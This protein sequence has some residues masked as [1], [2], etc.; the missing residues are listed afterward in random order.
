MKHTPILA[1][2]LIA[3]PALAQ[4]SAQTSLTIY[5]QDFA[6]VRSHVPLDLKEG[7]TEVTTTNVT[8][9]LEPDSVVLRDPAS[10][11]SFTIAEQNY[12][13]GV[14]N[15]DSL[16]EKFE[17][18][19]IDFQPG[20]GPNGAP[21]PTVQGTIIRAGRNG[22]QPLINSG[23]HLQ[24]L[25]PGTPL[26]PASTDGL[27]LKPTLRWQIYSPHAARLDAELA[28]ITHGMSWQSTYN[29]IAPETRDVGPTERGEV[30]GAVTIHNNTGTEFADA[31]IKLM[32][33]DVAKLQQLPVNGRAMYEMRAMA[34]SAPAPQVTQQAFDDFHLYDLNRSV[35]L[36]D[37]ET[38]Q[39]EFL[40]ATD[41]TM[42][43]VYEY[44]GA[45][46]SPFYPGNPNYQRTFNTGSNTKVSV[47][48]EFKNSTANHL[49]IPMPAGR[50]RLYR[51]SAGGQLEFVGETQI[52]HTP[53]EETIKLA[54]GNAFDITGERHQTDFHSDTRA[55]TLDETYSITLK[56]QKPSTAS[57]T[58]IEHL[59]RGENWKIAEQSTD[60]KKRDSNTIEIPLQVPAKGQT[61]YTYTVHYTW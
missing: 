43:R 52:G 7:P 31:H 40:N 20:P 22:E 18:K 53:T 51:R 9:S 45:G 42:S 57:V 28:Y 21:L 29:V 5:N 48:E 60:S 32:A 8:R 50:I 54:V 15:Q 39:V 10:K 36:R 34:G 37:G 58:V 12:D 41:V 2:F 61:T 55:H 33:G 27:L 4:Q 56:N 47:R 14:I 3:S 46:F 1:A 17:G 16:L 59:N 6:V 25:L 44:D 30:V 35:T 19:T 26:F 38:K 23:G 49:G 24:F 11:L 13:A